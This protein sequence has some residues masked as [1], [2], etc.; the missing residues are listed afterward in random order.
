MAGHRTAAASARAQPMSARATGVRTHANVRTAIPTLPTSPTPPPLAP[1]KKNGKPEKKTVPKTFANMPNVK[2]LTPTELTSLPAFIKENDDQLNDIGGLLIRPPLGHK[3]PKSL[4]RQSD[5]FLPKEQPLPFCP[6]KRDEDGNATLNQFEDQRRSTTVG[7]FMK[8]A[9][10]QDKD[11][12]FVNDLERYFWPKTLLK[13]EDEDDV[14]MYVYGND[15]DG[16]RFID[17]NGKL[18]EYEIDKQG[19]PSRKRTRDGKKKDDGKG[20]SAKRE[21]AKGGKKNVKG[22]KAGGRK[23]TVRRSRKTSSSGAGDIVARKLNFDESDIDDPESLDTMSG[24]DE[25]AENSP[26]FGDDRNEPS[27]AWKRANGVPRKARQ[28]RQEG[29]DKRCAT[30]AAFE[31]KGEELDKER[32]LNL[33]PPKK[34]PV[35]PAPKTL[36]EFLITFAGAA[37]RWRYNPSMAPMAERFPPLRTVWNYTNDGYVSDDDV[38]Q[39]AKGDFGGCTLRLQR[40][41]R[42]VDP[43][44]SMEEPRELLCDLDDRP[45]FA[46]VWSV[47]R[48]GS[49]KF[50]PLMPGINFP[51]FYIGARLTRFCW[52][53]EDLDLCSVGYL[54]PIKG[55]KPK[56]WYLIPPCDAKKFENFAAKKFAELGISVSR[57]QSAAW[58]VKWKTSMFHPNE[59]RAAGI[60]VYRMVQEPGDFIVTAPNAY[61]CG[62]NSGLNLL[63]AVNYC[64]EFWIPAGRKA[65]AKARKE[66]TPVVIP[67]EMLIAR[68]AQDMCE[69]AEKI[70]EDVL[71]AEVRPYHREVALMLGE[72]ELKKDPKQSDRAYTVAQALWA[73]L[74]DGEIAARLYQKKTGARILAWNETEFF[75]RELD[76]GADYGPDAGIQCTK[77]Q[78]T[79]HF[80][81]AACYDCSKEKRARC[82]NCFGERCC[83]TR[84]HETVIIRRYS[85]TKLMK[86]IHCL[87]RIAE[88]YISP[89]NEV[90]RHRMVWPGAT[91]HEQATAL[92]EVIEQENKEMEGVVEDVWTKDGIVKQEEEILDEGS[93]MTDEEME[94]ADRRRVEAMEPARK[95]R[96][97]TANGSGGR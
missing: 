57:E 5:M 94:A 74:R 54:H 8:M 32:K 10:K 3:H 1:R 87:E 72:E 53:V 44:R 11:A 29:N 60:T 83:G 51:M 33:P 4:L 22:K 84:G 9:R 73:Y 76:I 34:Y 13:V 66:S 89:Q 43:F 88:M 20:G 68:N 27:D 82:C 62:F 31:K 23:K 49:L 75:A 56:T 24:D 37:R 46:D 26:S 40:K 14:E 2:A 41:K 59:L 86:M 71:K 16:R 77:C 96:K 35:Y 25:L 12:A 17:K 50:L 38:N 79:S 52:H 65:A 39:S 67:V 58:L 70:G 81:A 36:R 80:Y 45:A 6:V 93:D 28:G 69:M 30:D 47:N 91:K 90:I 92:W 21:H 18:Q 78:Y 63:E 97:T 61:H 15:I 7:K 85:R 19:R 64:P 55:C 42:E 95:R 48:D